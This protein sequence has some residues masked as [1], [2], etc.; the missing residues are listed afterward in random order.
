MRRVVQDFKGASSRVSK[1][2]GKE[3]DSVAS[4]SYRARHPGSRSGEKREPRVKSNQARYQARRP[5]LRG[6]GKRKDVRR[7]LAVSHVVQ[8][9]KEEEE[10]GRM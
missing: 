10:R 5:G 7:F 4:C 1:G 8:D 6:R 9:F 2:K 3:R